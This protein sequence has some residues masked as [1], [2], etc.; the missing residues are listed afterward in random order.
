MR[1]DEDVYDQEELEEAGYSSKEE[2][3]EDMYD[4]MFPDGMDD[5]FDYDDFFHLND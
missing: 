1:I 4:M 2:F 3:E 5:G